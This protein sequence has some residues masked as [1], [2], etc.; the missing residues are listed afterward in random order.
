MLDHKLGL[1]RQVFP[2]DFVLGRLLLVQGY[3]HSAHSGGI[4]GVLRRTSNSD[5][6][7]LCEALNPQTVAKVG[8]V[9]DKLRAHSG[10]FG[11]YPVALMLQM[12]EPGRGFHA[13]GSFPMAAHPKVDQTDTLGRPHGM[14]YTHVID[15]TVF[16]SV[17]ATTITL[18]V[19]ANAYRIG[20]AVTRHASEKI[21]ALPT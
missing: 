15:S 19:M 3:L 11:A 17:P 1:L 10:C 16:P 18:T 7:D 21:C 20:K 12:T 9:V 13:G 4:N 2:K 6:F 14:A 8:Q 5:V